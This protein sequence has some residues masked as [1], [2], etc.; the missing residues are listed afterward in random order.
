MHF[1]SYLKN[2][3]PFVALIGLLFG[4]VSCGSYQYVGVDNDGI[5]GNLENRYEEAV[6]EIPNESKSNYYENYFKTKTIES[7]NLYAD[8]AIFTDIDSYESGN[9]IEND[10]ITN[11]YQGYAGWGQNSNNV[12]I[13]YIDNGWNNWGWNAGWGWNNWGWN[14]WGWNNWGWNNWRWNRWCWNNWGWNNWGWNAGWGWHDPFWG[15][16]FYGGWG[17][18]NG[19]ANNHYYT[20]RTSYNASRRNALY[21]SNNR[22]GLNSSRRSSVSSRNT[23]GITSKYNTTRRRSSINQNGVSVDRRSYETN[24]TRV[25][26]NTQRRGVSSSVRTP[27]ANSTTRSSSSSIR[28]SSST[29]NRSST[30]RNPSSNMYR[31]SA[32][33]NST[34]SPSRSSNSSSGSTIRSSSGSSRSSS[35]TSS[36]SGGR[37]GG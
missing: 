23:N 32:P 4:L 17:W 37:R 18:N 11:N 29:I 9:Y 35:G 7:Q 20:H 8:D 36:R 10:S 21:S 25:Y 28:R 12:T 26:S 14:N 33:S 22:T 6:V 3:I 30:N 31:R 16:S 2:K 5:Y 34:Y 27:S 15:P 13:N 1:Y 19:W 24:G